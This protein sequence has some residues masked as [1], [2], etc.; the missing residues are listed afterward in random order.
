MKRSFLRMQAAIAFLLLFICSDMAM[1]TS[2]PVKRHNWE[3]SMGPFQYNDQGACVRL[4]A[5]NLLFIKLHL[6]IAVNS[7]TNLPPIHFKYVF[8]INGTTVQTG[9][10]DQVTNNMIYAYNSFGTDHY[11]ATF[12]LPFDCSA[13]CGDGYFTF[14]LEYQ[15]VRPGMGTYIPYPIGAY[16]NAW[17]LGIFDV[18]NA[19]ATD[20]WAYETKPICCIKY[21]Q[22]KKPDSE[23]ARSGVYVEPIHHSQIGDS[24][25]E[26]FADVQSANTTSAKTGQLLVSPNPFNEAVGIEFNLSQPSKVVFNCLDAQGRQIK[27]FSEQY[28]SSGQQKAQL[29]MTGIPPGL[30][31]LRMSTDS[32]I[33]I[34]KMVKTGN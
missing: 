32:G 28:Q 34:V 22:I 5:D 8:K 26:P 17:P 20:N 33:Q 11:S 7:V 10:T 6:N 24:Q 19:L 13:Y 1:A 14:T 4:N 18:P 15:M 29:D 27:S 3:N 2:V 16:P 9:V 25:S 23:F 30:Y 12:P 31:Y 21:N